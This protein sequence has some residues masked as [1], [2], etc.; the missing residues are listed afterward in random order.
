MIRQSRTPANQASLTMTPSAPSNNSRKY[1]F[2][3]KASNFSEMAFARGQ[4]TIV[5]PEAL[6]SIIEAQTPKKPPLGPDNHREKALNI[7]F[8]H[9]ARKG[10]H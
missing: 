1:L 7:I 9:F 6:S 4:Q 8:K 10:L 2:E 3:E 5:E